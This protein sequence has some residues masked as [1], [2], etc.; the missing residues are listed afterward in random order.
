MFLHSTG[1]PIQ[2]GKKIL[3]LAN[4][5]QGREGVRRKQQLAPIIGGAVPFL[6]T[7]DGPNRKQY[8]F[9]RPS[10]AKKDDS[11][12]PGFLVSNPCCLGA[13][14]LQ[15][16]PDILLRY[17]SGICTVIGT[18]KI[19]GKACNCPFNPRRC[20]LLQVEMQFISEL[21]NRP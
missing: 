15:A 2:R 10:A 11:P 6:S 5:D 4:E 1:K 9:Q 12:L 14:F 17:R 19:S 21:N 16:G 7:D 18:T 8:F 3:E 20:E 13:L